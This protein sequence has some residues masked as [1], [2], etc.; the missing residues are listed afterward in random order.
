MS[1]ALEAINSKLEEASTPAIHGL[2]GICIDEA[3]ACGLSRRH[4]V[5]LALEAVLSHDRTPA[6]AKEIAAAVY[7]AAFGPRP[8][9]TIL[10]LLQLLDAGDTSLNVLSVLCFGEALAASDRATLTAMEEAPLPHRTRLKPLWSG[11]SD[12]WSCHR[13]TLDDVGDHGDDDEEA[14]AHHR[15]QHTCPLA[16]SRSAWRV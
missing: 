6:K 2:V 10:A 9:T 11:C 3:T 14:D 4:G 15:R 1:I 8:V 16:S 13:R 5:R 7:D 12:Q